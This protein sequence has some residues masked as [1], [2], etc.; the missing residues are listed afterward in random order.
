MPFPDCGLP[1]LWQSTRSAQHFAW[2]Q[3]WTAALQMQSLSFGE[4]TNTN[5]SFAVCQDGHQCRCVSSE[6]RFSITS[7]RF[8]S[9]A[10][11]NLLLLG[12]VPQ[13]GALAAVSDAE[14][15]SPGWALPPGG[16]SFILGCALKHGFQG[17]CHLPTWPSHRPS[18][19]IRQKF[20]LW[21]TDSQGKLPGH[22]IIS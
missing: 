12:N 22:P 11:D 14:F 1:Y 3:G 4:G 5:R 7:T 17:L 19:A 21:Y 20:V 8:T 15:P 18:A 9:Q 16:H 6:V 13:E 2:A 10:I